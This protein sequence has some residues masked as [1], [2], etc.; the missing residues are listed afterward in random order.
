MLADAPDAAWA[1]IVREEIFGP[2]VVASRFSDTEQVVSMANDT[3]YGLAAGVWTQNV[4]TAH[5]MAARIQAGTV[6]VNSYG[7][8][9]PSMPFGGM[10]ESGW[11]REMGHNALDNY[12]E[13]K[14][15]VA[16]LA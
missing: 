5:Q 14:S 6:W 10:K 7:V 12:L 3:R 13:T 16:Q 2:V 9:D 15:V 4:A 11:G 8:F 1:R